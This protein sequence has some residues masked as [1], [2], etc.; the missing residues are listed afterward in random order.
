[1][2]KRALR[3]PLEDVIGVG[4][5]IALLVL[6][7]VN[8]FMRYVLNTGIGWSEEISR[9][10]LIWMVYAGIATGI[11]T[12]THVRI[13]VVDRL[14][15]PAVRRVLAVVNGVLLLAY[16]VLV[17]WIFAD[18]VGRFAGL[19]SPASGLSMGYAYSAVLAGAALGAARLLVTWVLGGS[20]A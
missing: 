2:W 18:L 12:R 3:F 7:S 1:M 8:V 4:L 14:V 15:G 20:R 17:I 5:M 9:Y 10:L 13:D 6:M 19:R 16:L 11:R